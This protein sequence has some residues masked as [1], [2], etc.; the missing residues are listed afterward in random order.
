MFYVCHWHDNSQVDTDIDECTDPAVLLNCSA[1]E[2]LE[3]NNMDGSF[4]CDCKAGY[5]RQSSGQCEGNTAFLK[6]YECLNSRSKHIASESTDVNECMDTSSHTCPQAG[7]EDCQN[8]D[9]S[10][11]CICK[12]GF[13]R[14]DTNQQCLG[15]CVSAVLLDVSLYFISR[16]RQ[17]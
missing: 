10:F 6:H 16:Y 17:M 2:N 4:T 7:N 11:A 8:T 1:A 15:K 13:R 12:I 14:I 9:G 5:S 3:C